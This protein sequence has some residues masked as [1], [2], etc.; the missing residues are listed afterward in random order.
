MG[1]LIKQEPGYPGATKHVWLMVALMS[2]NA[3]H[4]PSNWIRDVIFNNEIRPFK[5]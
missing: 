2:P 5:K 3:G 1:N 4:R